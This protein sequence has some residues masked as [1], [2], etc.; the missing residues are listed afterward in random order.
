MRSTVHPGSTCNRI[1][2]AE[3]YFTACAEHEVFEEVSIVTAKSE[4]A[5]LAFQAAAEVVLESTGDISQTE[6]LKAS[7]FIMDERKVHVQECVTVDSNGMSVCINATSVDDDDAV[8]RAL[9]MIADALQHLGNDHGT[10]YFGE[11]LHFSS[12]E[13]QLA[14]T[15]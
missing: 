11:K 13:V 1:K 15:H 7:A 6:L 2:W 14:T 3:L 12:A 8:W 4:Y 10:V 5:N 9:D